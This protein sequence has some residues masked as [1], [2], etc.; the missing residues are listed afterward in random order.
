MPGQPN[1]TCWTVLRAASAGDAAARSTFARSYAEPIRAYLANRW[2]GRSLSAEVDDAI[3]DSFLE[4]LKPGGV[5]ERADPD[6]GD[7]RALLFGVVRNVARRYEERAVHAGRLAPDTS[8]H[9]EELPYTADPLSRVF[10]RAWARSLL[11]EAVLRHEQAADA[12]GPEARRRFR[13]LGLRHDEGLPVRDIAAALGEA[14]TA[15]VHNDYRRARREFA[16]H[17]R[18]VVA[19]HAGGRAVDV[20]AECRQLTELL[21]P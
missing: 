5:L 4:C 10:D 13:I 19:A 17:L 14:D 20:D 11:R 18:A 6:R 1:E 16:I 7:F 15:R 8:V 12:A 2:R 21:G 9:V 3:Q